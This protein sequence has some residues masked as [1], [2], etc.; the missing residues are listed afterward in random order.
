VKKLIFA[1][2]VVF[3]L[4]AVSAEVQA[5]AEGAKAKGASGKRGGKVSK[6][7]EAG[8]LKACG[9]D[10]ATFCNGVEPGPKLGK[11]LMENEAELDAGCLEA[12]KKMPTD[13]KSKGAKGGKGGAAN[14]EAEAAL[15]KSCKADLAKFCKDIGPGPEQGQCLM[16]HESELAAECGRTLKSLPPPDQEGGEGQGGQ[17]NQKAGAALMKACKDDAAKLCKGVAQGPEQGQCLMEHESE[18]SA[19][20]GKTLKSLPPPEQGGGK[21]GQGGPAALMKAC[22]NDMNKFCKDIAPGPQKGRC[23]KEHET[24]LSAECGKTLKSMPPPGEDGQEGAGQ[25][26]SGQKGGQR[27]G[28]SQKGGQG[29]GGPGRGGPGGEEGGPGG[30]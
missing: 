5:Q 30:D 25:G 27:K 28:G 14:Q 22:K 26:R 21:G 7:S 6:Q 15:G 23:L 8:L 29:R 10:I 2:A 9:E 11:C 20:C 17:D 16:E 19:E 13:Q 18:L 1:A 4:C 24:E 12:V 3:G